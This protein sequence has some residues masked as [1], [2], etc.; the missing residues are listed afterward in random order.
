MKTSRERTQ[1]KRISDSERLTC[2]PGRAPRT[3]RSLSMIAL[4]SCSTA[5]VAVAYGVGS[6]RAEARA[7]LA[8][9]E[10]E[11]EAKGRGGRDARGEAHAAA[12][13]LRDACGHE[14]RGNLHS[15]RRGGASAQ[16]TLINHGNMP[17]K[18]GKRWERGEGRGKF[19]P[20]A[21]CA[22]YLVPCPTLWQT[23]PAHKSSNTCF[24]VMDGRAMA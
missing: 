19:N 2:F 5:I 8:G 12:R 13:R 24:F 3:S 16:A 21:P 4:T 22:E 23:K 9:G 11:P 18:G 10:A 6:G 7:A 20:N 17:G 1:R 15:T 14:A